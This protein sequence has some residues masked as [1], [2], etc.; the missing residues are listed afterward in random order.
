MLSTVSTTSGFSGKRC[1]TGGSLPCLTN[2]ANIGASLYLAAG[3]AVGATVGGLVASGGFVAG[4]AVGATDD[5][6]DETGGGGALVGSGVGVAHATKAASTKINAT[7]KRCFFIF[8]F[9][10]SLRSNNHAL[11]F[12]FHT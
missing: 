12:S 6:D 4:T 5:A 9:S 2:S 7:N 10:S 1:S 11:R 8:F 3:T